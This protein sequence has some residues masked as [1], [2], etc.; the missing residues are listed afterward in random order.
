[1]VENAASLEPGVYAVPARH[2]R[3]HRGAQARDDGRHR[4]TTLTA[5]QASTSRRWTGRDRLGQCPI[6][7]R[8][9]RTIWWGRGRRPCPPR[10]FS[11]TRRVC[12]SWATFS[13]ATSTRASARRS[14]R[15]LSAARPRSAW[16]P[17]SRVALW[18]ANET[19][20]YRDGGRRTSPAST[21]SRRTYP[22]LGRPRSTSL[23]APSACVCSP[24]TTPTCPCRS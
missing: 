6:E 8:I 11:S 10:C 13:C 12:R 5:E 15:W 19:E 2:R 18:A 20:G 24:T 9:P 1:M 22:R 16:R 21:R 4:S 3:G 7:D 23:G 14:G 17:R